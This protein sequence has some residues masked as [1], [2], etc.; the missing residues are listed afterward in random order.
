VTLRQHKSAHRRKRIGASLLTTVLC[1][2][3]LAATP[4]PAQAVNPPQTWRSP[5]CVDGSNNPLDFAYPTTQLVPSFAPNVLGTNGTW[6]G[7]LNLYNTAVGTGVI[8]QHQRGT[9]TSNSIS[10]FLNKE[11][12]GGPFAFGIRVETS[13]A[14]NAAMT[15]VNNANSLEVA[16]TWGGHA[17]P[18]DITDATDDISLGLDDT[19]RWLLWGQG[20]QRVSDN[21]TPSNPADDYDIG[22]ALFRMDAL[23]PYTSSGLHAKK[24]WPVVPPPA[25]DSGVTSAAMTASDVDA[26]S[27]VSHDVYYSQI[28]GTH[29]S[30]T[31]K[32]R[33][34]RMTTTTTQLFGV[35]NAVVA[36]SAVTDIALPAPF[37]APS[38]PNGLVVNVIDVS[39]NG[40]YLLFGVFD[41]SGVTDGGNVHYYV[42][43]NTTGVAK[44]PPPAPA[45][46]PQYL[47]IGVGNDGTMA[48]AQMV[49]TATPIEPKVIKWDSNVW[50]VGPAEDRYSNGPG[51]Q[52]TMISGDGSTVA[53]M[54]RNPLNVYDTHGLDDMATVAMADVPAPPMGH[55]PTANGGPDKTV[56]EGSSVTLN[57]SAS[58][59]NDQDQPLLSYSFDK[60]RDGTV[61]QAGTSPSFTMTAGDGPG[62]VD[63]GV[64]VTD[65][66]G[67]SAEDVVTV[68]STNVP[69]VINQAN[70]TPRTG[71]AGVT[72][73]TYST[74]SVTDAGGDSVTVQW[75][76][77]G[78]NTFDY[79]GPTPPAQVFSTSG[80]FNGKVRATDK[81]G[82]ITTATLPTVTVSQAVG[83]PP[84][85]NAGPD[86]TVDEGS[87]VT[88][89][90]SGSSA[91]DPGQV[92]GTYRF[93]KGRDGTIE[94]SGT[95]PT[96]TFNAPDGPA[97][98]EVGVVVLD[99]DGTSAEDVAVVTVNNAPPTVNGADVNPKF[100]QAGVTPFVYSLSSVSDPGGDATTVAW[101][102]D[103]DG[104]TD[105]SG[106]AP[107]PHTF[108]FGG[109]YD[110]TVKA[111]D[112]DGATTTV[113]LATVTVTG[114][115]LPTADAGPD[116]TSGEGSAVTIDASA[117]S[118]NDAGQTISQYRFDLGDD[119]SFE[120]QGASP[121]FTFTA[122]DGPSTTQ[123]AVVVVDPDGP[124][125][126]DV[127][128]V[129]SQNVAP[130]VVGAGVNPTSGVAG[131][132]TFSFTAG[133]VS[134]AGGD[135]VSLAWDF[136][137]NG[138]TDA[139][140]AVPP[141]FK[142]PE[143][144]T[145]TPKL[146]ATDDDGA[147]TAVTLPA[148]TVAGRPPTAN[149]GPD[150]TVSEGSA[151]TID[152]SASS[153]NDSGQSITAYRFDLGNDGSVE[154]QGA[155]PTF[156]FTAPNGPAAL[157]VGVVVVDPDSTSAAD[158]AAVNV[159][160]AAPVV[161]GAAVSPGFGTAGTTAFTYSVASVSDPGGD[162]VTVAWDFDAD[163]TVD[164]TGSSPAPHVFA[165]AG[166]YSAKLTATDSDG[167][168]VSVNLPVVTVTSGT[169]GGP[170]DDD[171]HDGIRNKFDGAP[172]DPT[173]ANLNTLCGSGTFPGTPS[174]SAGASGCLTY[175][176]F[177]RLLLGSFRLNDGPVHFDGLWLFA[178]GRVRTAPNVA[179]YRGRSLNGF[180]WTQGFLW[181]NY[182]IA[183]FDNGPS[184]DRIV[185]E[186][187]GPGALVYETNQIL[188]GGDLT[189]G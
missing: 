1:I 178:Q 176:S 84:T 47:P 24:D 130:S 43:D 150:K 35:W 183:V 101:D 77:N 160:N 100:G 66:D 21:G 121:T 104:S 151:V 109:S 15:Y 58:S 53:F 152:A 12:T 163:G 175:S 107:A 10:R 49:E 159:T 133:L 186:V 174:G 74:Q 62:S 38:Q 124:S 96:F 112:D 157:T 72:Q 171:D 65:P 154:Q 29:P 27:P 177:W 75:D 64:K 142:Y 30:E 55:L 184:G 57:A 34:V 166:T 73:F 105:A 145:Y 42:R 28:T 31:Q 81:D 187:H 136:D 103:G 182:E 132:T 98:V 33:K 60:G 46:Q 5:C 108:A 129:T 11:S 139:T 114:G 135:A 51:A 79:T 54:T 95:S 9:S 165:S 162:V 45:G 180:S 56:A 23:I 76:F 141:G 189:V 169:G 99:P 118:P 40:R 97:T 93:D 80:T 167:A 158:T 120:Q 172:A 32:L 113:A 92:I 41:R 20:L 18:A 123:V 179:Y 36:Y 117:S 110:G 48:V 50:P 63:V 146:T 17:Y 153:S 37:D 115:Q 173:L 8:F 87:S 111:T 147:A 140:G 185:A 116:Q 148:V 6:A 7:F 22:G 122:P 44:Q 68:T 2:A 134:D 3:A 155:S 67:T 25:V 89:D 127:A 19:G 149:A 106:A 90:A 128:A 143:R 52:Y 168:V 119:G 78:D 4:E 88:I 137:G 86:K 164:A 181:A 61:E 94:Q 170:D 85:A 16:S 126:P 59:S 125:A 70:V 156:T 91:N 82:G 14:G 138:T 26:G 69:P 71:T 161:A 188:T 144:G 102:F 131:T 83:M 39:S 13:D